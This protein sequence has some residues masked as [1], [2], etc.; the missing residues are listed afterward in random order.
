MND[1]LNPVL[2]WFFTAPAWLVGPAFVAV[3][4]VGGV[5][6]GRFLTLRVGRAKSAGSQPVDPVVAARTRRRRRI[7]LGATALLL[8]GALLAQLI[9]VVA[10]GLE[11]AASRAELKTQV[12]SWTVEREPWLDPATDGDSW[13]AYEEVARE[14]A[15]MTPDEKATL[16]HAGDTKVDEGV[17]ADCRP[18]MKRHGA[19]LTVLRTAAA[20]GTVTVPVQEKRGHIGATELLMPT[21]SGL[22]SASELIAASAKLKSDDGDWDGA[23]CDIGIGL[24]MGCDLCRNSPLIPYLGGRAVTGITLQ[25]AAVLLKSPL[26]PRQAAERLAS[27]LARLEREM[28]GL[29]HAAR[30]ERVLVQESLVLLQ[31]GKLDGMDKQI[32]AGFRLSEW[33]NGLSL[34]I[35]ALD[36]DREWNAYVLEI[37]QFASLPWNDANEIHTRWMARSLGGPHGRPIVAA[38]FQDMTGLEET[39]RLVTAHLSLALAAARYRAGTEHAL[40]VDP[41]TRGSIHAATRNEMRVFWSEGTNGDQGGTGDWWGGTSASRWPDTVLEVPR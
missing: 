33:R 35:A 13:P 17:W 6:L 1:D 20:R 39:S 38:F 18:I 26:L 19:L 36:V 9:R 12:G 11:F 28:P 3:I 27:L 5:L 15:A 14:C 30:A 25:A 41:F 37:G 7:V 32:T 10:A 24:Q 34:S 29:Q 16:H 4:T 40:P 22:R 31:Q 23:V 2:R 21:L 8:V